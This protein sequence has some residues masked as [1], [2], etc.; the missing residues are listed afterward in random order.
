MRFGAQPGQLELAA[1]LGSILEINLRNSLAISDGSPV[2]FVTRDI[3][4]VMVIVLAVVLIGLASS[5][6]RSKRRRT[7]HQIHDMVDA[8]EHASTKQVDHV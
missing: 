1:V 6:F 3:S 2:V 7:N 4:L 8:A 5:T